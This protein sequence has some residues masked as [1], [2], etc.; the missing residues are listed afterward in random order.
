MGI[1][2]GER[3]KRPEC[4]GH[5]QVRNH[6]HHAEKKRDRVEVD[7]A[8]SLLEAKGPDGDHRRAA[9]ESDARAVETQARNPAYRHAD[10]GQNENDER[11]VAFWSQEL[12]A[13]SIASGFNFWLMA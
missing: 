1:F 10:I 3:A 4:A 13:P 11:Y 9:Q 2:D 12:E 6:D 5:L 8:E 7:C